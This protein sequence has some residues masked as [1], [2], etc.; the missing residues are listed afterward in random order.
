MFTIS[1]VNLDHGSRLV[2]LINLKNHMSGEG[3][4]FTNHVD[5]V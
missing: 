3:P 1:F 2:K 4:I 5:K